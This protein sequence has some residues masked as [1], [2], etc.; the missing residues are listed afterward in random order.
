MRDLILKPRFYYGLLGLSVGMILVSS[1]SNYKLNGDL[2]KVQKAN[3][4]LGICF[5]RVTQT[6]TSLMIKDF[7]SGYLNNDFR[8]NSADCIDEVGRIATEMGMTAGTTKSLN[9]LKSD[10][11]WF[12]QKV[13][14]VLSMAKA[15]DMNLQQSNITD[16]YSELEGLKAEV[17]DSFSKQTDGLSQFRTLGLAG[18]IFSLITLMISM[19]SFLFVGRVKAKEL[20][21]I[22]K[23]AE[24]ID[25][26][27][28]SE[29]ST[30]LARFFQSLGVPSLEA[31]VLTAFDGKI[32]AVNN[33]EDQLIKMNTIETERYEIEVPEDL[34][35]IEVEETSDF[36]IALT[37]ALDRVQQKA[38]QHGIVMDTDLQDD[39]QILANREALDQLLY[40][41]LSFG[42]DAS[43]TSEES[44]RV[45]LRSNPL[46]GIAYLKMKV[47]GHAFSE[48]EMKILNGGEPTSETNVNLLLLRELISD[49][50][51]TLAV[52]NIH[53][54][55]SSRI[56]SEIEIVFARSKDIVESQSNVKV[57]KGNKAE[58]KAYFERETTL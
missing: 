46:G 22:D 50:N 36:H 7:S 35:N 30:L 9:N 5:Q 58:I 24:L 44:R 55:T 37:T 20:K 3:A 1:L 25:S 27:S 47:V 29:L 54:S 8:S 52:R 18:I 31:K 33:L 19:L 48:D 13:T 21:A 28:S 39:F 26:N 57:V 12:D 16:K 34:L 53:N 10:L 38:F 43:L 6:F 4:G 41:S 14:K 49:A 45:I 51:A 11:H 15:E 42:L 56:E 23:A 32:E 2:Q 40:Y 17:E